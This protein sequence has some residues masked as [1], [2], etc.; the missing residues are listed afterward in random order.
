[1]KAKNIDGLQK[2]LYIDED[3]KE[4]GLLPGITR[5][6]TFSPSSPSPKSRSSVLRWFKRWCP[7]VDTKYHRQHWK[8]AAEP[9][10]IDRRMA[11]A[12]GQPVQ[13]T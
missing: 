7:T 5:R 9:A 6:F 13:F 8:E 3:K 2:V 11:L 4:L 1:M 12:T 10:L